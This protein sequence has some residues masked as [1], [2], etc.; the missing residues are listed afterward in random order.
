MHH[1]LLEFSTNTIKGYL[2]IIN[3]Y[4]QTQ[5]EDGRQ[6]WEDDL[7]MLKDD[8]QQRLELLFI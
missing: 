4:K 3:N 1:A 7:I 6:A 2:L 5:T 8:I